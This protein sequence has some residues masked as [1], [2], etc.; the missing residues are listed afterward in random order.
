[1]RIGK[2]ALASKMSPIA[3]LTYS[4]NAG[5]VWSQVKS[6]VFSKLDNGHLLGIQEK[7]L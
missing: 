2:D 4:K 7:I 6:L 5:L 1:M 3:E